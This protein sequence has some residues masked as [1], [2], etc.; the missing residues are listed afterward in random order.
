MTLDPDPTAAEALDAYEE[1]LAKVQECDV[2]APARPD[3]PGKGKQTFSEFYGRTSQDDREEDI[4]LT[5][6]IQEC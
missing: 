6:T 5:I 2:D 3:Y 1:Y 4:E